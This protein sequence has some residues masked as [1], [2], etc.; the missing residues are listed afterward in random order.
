MFQNNLA[1]RKDVENFVEDNCENL[2]FKVQ[3]L[4]QNLSKTQIYFQECVIS[5][6]Q[7]RKESSELLQA[8]DQLIN[9]T[10][11]TKFPI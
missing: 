1:L 4:L 11:C 2:P 9:T 7:G 6:Q 3:T 5:M 8:M 10:A